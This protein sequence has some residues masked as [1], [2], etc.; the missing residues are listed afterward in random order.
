MNGA[1]TVGRASSSAR[2]SDRD[3]QDFAVQHLEHHGVVK[4]RQQR[5]T[6]RLIVRQGFQLRKA[7]RPRSDGIE[8][9]GQL[10]EKSR[11]EAGRLFIRGTAGRNQSLPRLPPE[12]G[13]S[14]LGLAGLPLPLLGEHIRGRPGASRAGTIDG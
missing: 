4:R 6:V 10:V 11:A 1:T 14:R 2:M 7:E 12:C 13:E 9:V 8:S 3:H 5:A